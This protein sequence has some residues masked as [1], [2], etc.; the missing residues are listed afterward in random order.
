MG[1]FVYCYTA[2]GKSTVGKKYS[3]VID[4]ESTLYKYVGKVKEIENEKGTR[5]EINI[6]YPNNYFKALEEAKNKYD[7]I[8][9]SDSICDSWLKENNIEYWQVYPNIELK[10]EYLERMKNRGN[11]QDF[12]DYQ[13][14]L[15]EEWVNGCK[16]DQYA[17]KHIELKSGQFLEDVLPNLKL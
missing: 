5:R 17:S 13:A 9:I 10:Q 2:T 6:D 8:L 16:F 14:K 3:N 1:V 12:I 7:Y 11:N 4:M 15:W